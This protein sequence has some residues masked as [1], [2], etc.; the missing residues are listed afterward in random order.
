MAAP[1]LFTLFCP[2]REL[3]DHP[4]GSGSFGRLRDQFRRFVVGIGNKL[5]LHDGQGMAPERGLKVL[6][7]KSL[8]LVNA[9]GDR[10]LLREE[11]GIQ[12]RLVFHQSVERNFE[13]QPPGHLYY[14]SGATISGI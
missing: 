3:R 9:K 14:E 11:L 1:K 7:S 4:V 10:A 8:L 2:S 13:L 6:R 12:A 5:V